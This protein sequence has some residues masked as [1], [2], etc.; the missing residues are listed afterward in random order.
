MHKTLY[1]V[2]NYIECEPAESDLRVR[3]VMEG[4]LTV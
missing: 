2:T 3:D 1:P 4:D